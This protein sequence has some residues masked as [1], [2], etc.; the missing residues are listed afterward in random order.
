MM[1]G[2]NNNRI[3]D[4]YFN[5]SYLKCKSVGKT[6]TYFYIVRFLLLVIFIPIDY[7]VIKS[8][9]FLYQLFLIL[10]IVFNFLYAALCFWFYASHI[11]DFSKIMRIATDM[12]HSIVPDYQ[13]SD[14]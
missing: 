1:E 11:K 12:N 10:A 3:V 6:Q 5:N 14:Q 7:I 2:L 9:S 13:Q 4:K 8:D